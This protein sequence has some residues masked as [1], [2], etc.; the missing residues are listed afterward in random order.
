MPQ[1]PGAVTCSLHT[2]QRFS[3]AGNFYTHGDSLWLQTVD[4]DPRMKR[5]S[6]GSYSLQGP[7][8]IWLPL[9]ICPILKMYPHTEALV[10]RSGAMVFRVMENASS[11]ASTLL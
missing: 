5:D 4:V 8:R 9:D 7:K 1:S 2:E 3:K 10:S 11:P 6:E